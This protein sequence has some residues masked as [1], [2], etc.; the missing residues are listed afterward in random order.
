MGIK[1][2]LRAARLDLNLNKARSPAFG[3]IQTALL[4]YNLRAGRPSF[5]TAATCLESAGGTGFATLV[6]ES[7]AAGPAADVGAAADAEVLCA[8]GVHTAAAAPVD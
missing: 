5:H 2:R 1:M 6:N 3:V 4:R 8:A 7:V